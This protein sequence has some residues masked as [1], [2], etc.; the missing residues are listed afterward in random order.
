MLEALEDLATRL[1]ATCRKQQL[2]ASTAELASVAG[3]G[4]GDTTFGIDTAPESVVA[5]W[6][7]ELANAGPL[8]I[9]TE[10]SG[11][12]HLG[13]G[14]A[15]FQVLDDFDHGGPRVVVDPVDG[16]RNLMFDLR[17]AWAAIASAP[18]GKEA[19]RLA[20][21]TL[22][23]V[24]ELGTSRHGRALRLVGEVDGGCHE[25]LYE[26][27]PEGLG[28]RVWRR[29]LVVD[30]DPRIDQ[31][32]LPFFRYHPASRVEL[33]RLEAA[34]FERLRLDEQADL[35]SIFDDQYISNTGQ[36]V[37]LSQG[38]YRMIADLRGLLVNTDGSPSVTSKPYD[39]A[40]AVVCA[41]AA[42]AL[43]EDPA[44]QPLDVPLDATTRVS[45]V[46]YTNA[47]T[48]SRLR[49]HLLAILALE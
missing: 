39:I 45:F 30:A 9:L 2:G 4:A 5:A 46:A 8:S 17:P 29:E 38:R 37:L 12:R 26:L 18:A 32:F 48:A 36:L 47:A 22:G 41:R 10:D 24:Q 44:G 15:G 25:A 40:A 11:W 21:L 23:V 43:V 42:G 49:P 33:A 27:S 19:P 7:E 3:V 6:A 20:D 1:A 28:V 14:D 34:F 35:R 16:S 13:P 31:G